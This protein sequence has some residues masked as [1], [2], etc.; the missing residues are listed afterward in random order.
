MADTKQRQM[1]ALDRA[2]YAVAPQWG[3]NRLRARLAVRHYEAASVGRRTA[4]WSRS[5]TDVNAAN[6]PAL[7]LLRDHARDLVRNN[8]WAAEGKRVIVDH[9]IGYGIRPKA[10]GT[11]ADRANYLWRRWADTTE[12]DADGKLDMSG[13][14][15][16]ALSTIVESGEV[17]IRRR[18][19]KPEDGLS[20][21]I[22][23]QILEP[24][25]LDMTR[26]G[27]TNP[28][29][30]NV[31][32]QGKEYDK[33][34][35][36][37]AYW[38]YE[39]HPGASGVWPLSYTGLTS[40]R[41]S[42]E[43]IEHVYRIDRPGQVRGVSW[44]APAILNLKDFDEYE[45]A[46]LMQAKVAALFSAAVTDV[47]GDGAPLGDEDVED[48]VLDTLEPGMILHLPPG[49][50][51]KFG[52]PPVGADNGFSTRQLRRVAAGLGVTY[53]DLT[54]DYSQVNF[55]S[56]RMGRLKHWAHVRSWQW[57][58]LVPQL[59]G[60]VWYWFMQALVLQNEVPAEYP[61]ATWTAP[62]MPML[63]PDKEGLAY[64]RNV[65]TGMMTPDEMVREQGSDPE[66]HWAEYEKRMKDLKKRGIVLDCDA[67]QTTQTGQF[68][69]EKPAAVSAPPAQAS[70][71]PPADGGQATEG[72]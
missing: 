28:E 3:M 47:N 59:C 7:A 30:G 46:S 20:V 19:R 26:D 44:F 72:T 4:G 56:G 11:G 38:L 33:I 5:N 63:E 10:E 53:E 50:D 70:G 22:Q 23:L 18:W 48:P 49:R 36:C 51:V 37:V 35:R 21:P 6:K 1:N 41:Y 8:A 45:D 60:S 69:A 71:T 13:L 2:I 42:A 65:R 27:T 15:A 17:I 29:N 25:F 61:T 57:R 54:G 43:D 34:G 16:L 58:M 40:R 67:S 64:Q 9:T 68:Q 31:I 66:T 52:T 55:S 32:V 39:K 12:C 24:D 62:A 14:Q